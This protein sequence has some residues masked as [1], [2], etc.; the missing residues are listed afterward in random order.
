MNTVSLIGRLTEEPELKMM[1]SGIAVVSFR[2][3]VDRPT[4]DKQ[5]DFI[6]CVAWRHVA[7]FLSKYL[8]KGKRIGLTGS[9]QV[10]TYD[11]KDGKKVYVT[12]VIASNVYFADGK[13][14]EYAP[15]PQVN[16]TPPTP[17]SNNF[18]VQSSSEDDDYPF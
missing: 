8:N 12:E 4:K 16:S 11:D 1:Q 14:N 5:T 3:A 10:R 6:S 13:T 17:A 7:E 18:A 2:L 9:I 15:A